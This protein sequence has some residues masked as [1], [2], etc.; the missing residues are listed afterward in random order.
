MSIR[1]P[2]GLLGCAMLLVHGVRT[3][4]GEA[5]QVRVPA[6]F[7]E[8]H[9]DFHLAVTD[10]FQFHSRDEGDDVAP[11]VDG[12]LRPFREGANDAGAAS[13][14]LFCNSCEHASSV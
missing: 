5:L 14:M 6:L 13:E 11:R 12:R 7:V 1:I 10:A 2:L 3:L 4:L 9:I 8:R